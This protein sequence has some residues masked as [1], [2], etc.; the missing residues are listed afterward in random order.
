[1]NNFNYCTAGT[2]TVSFT[3]G[4]NDIT[5]SADLGSSLTSSATWIPDAWLDW[6]PPACLRDKY[7][8]TVHIVR[9]YKGA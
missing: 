7:L 1:M 2:D 5:F 8:P 3:D 6:L 9:S 4:T